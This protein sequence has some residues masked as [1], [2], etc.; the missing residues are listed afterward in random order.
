[1][2][3]MPQAPQLIPAY[4]TF[5]RLLLVFSQHTQKTTTLHTKHTTPNTILHTNYT[6]QTRSMS[7]TSQISKLAISVIV[8]ITASVPPTTICSSTTK[9]ATLTLWWQKPIFTVSSCTKQTWRQCS[10]KSVVDV[11]YP[12][13]DFARAG[14]SGPS[15]REVGWLVAS[16]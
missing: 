16:T 14:A 8:C 9:L 15:P 6:L 11:I 12:K 3:A 1:M 5:S 7:Q 2:Q 4:S 13:S 10:T